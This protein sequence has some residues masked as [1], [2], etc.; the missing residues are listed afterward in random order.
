LPGLRMGDECGMY[1]GFMIYV[2][3]DLGGL[4]LFIQEENFAEILI[5][6][7]LDILMICLSSEVQFVDFEAPDDVLCECLR[8]IILLVIHGQDYNREK[9]KSKIQQIIRKKSKNIDLLLYF[10]YSLDFIKEVFHVR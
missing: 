7:A 3:I 9:I 2:F 6:K 4:N 5:G 10:W 1:K 8:V